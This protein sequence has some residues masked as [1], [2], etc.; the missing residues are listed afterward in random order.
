MLGLLGTW[1]QKHLLARA[2]RVGL[3]GARSR[4]VR[5][6]GGAS[7]SSTGQKP[8]CPQAAPVTAWLS[9]Q[10]GQVTAEPPANG[11]VTFRWVI[12]CGLMADLA[13]FLQPQ[14]SVAYKERMHECFR[15]YRLPAPRYPCQRGPPP[16]ST[17]PP[18]RAWRVMSQPRNW[19]GLMET[20][21]AH[22][23]SFLCLAVFPQEERGGLGC[24]VGREMAPQTHPC[25]EP[26]DVNMSHG[27]RE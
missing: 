7:A 11:T 19:Q 2:V 27:H 21:P 9:P 8:K 1:K 25:P 24:G 6:G 14:G 18:G 22:T 26:P 20:P 3:L 16:P 13:L 5:G 4:A 15:R 23:A 17:A 10:S 12:A